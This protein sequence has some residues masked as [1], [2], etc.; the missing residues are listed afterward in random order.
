M[1]HLISYFQLMTNLTYNKVFRTYRLKV[2]VYLFQLFIQP[3][4]RRDHGQKETYHIS[5]LTC[6][7]K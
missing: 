7:P 4:S 6:S 1:F 3:Q 5:Y 2:G